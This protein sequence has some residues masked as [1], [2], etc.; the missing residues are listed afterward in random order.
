MFHVPVSSISPAEIFSSSWHLRVLLIFKRSSLIPDENLFTF[1]RSYCWNAT[2]FSIIWGTG[3]Q[4]KEKGWPLLEDNTRSQL[5]VNVLI[6][7]LKFST[8]FFFFCLEMDG[9]PPPWETARIT[10]SFKENPASSFSCRSL[11]CYWSL[12]NSKVYFLSVL[13]GWVL[14]PLNSVLCEMVEDT[15]LS[16]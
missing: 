3:M 11:C 15:R 7:A 6:W 16:G 5:N 1:P 2:R 14:Q 4:L 13:M 8:L 9:S 12:G 10:F